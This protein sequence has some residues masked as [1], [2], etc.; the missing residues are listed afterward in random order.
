MGSAHVS[1]INQKQAGKAEWVRVHRSGLFL[2]LEDPLA[3]VGPNPAPEEEP[4]QD[5]LVVQ[6]PGCYQSLI[7]Q[8]RRIRWI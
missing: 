2:L 1:A 6:T 3:E 8:V 4:L 5:D 7:L